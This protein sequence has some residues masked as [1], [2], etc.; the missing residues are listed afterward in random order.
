MM[1]CGVGLLLRV[2]EVLLSCLAPDQPVCRSY[3]L[4]IPRAPKT[5]EKFQALAT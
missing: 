3:W 4:K 1:F 5:K 2:K